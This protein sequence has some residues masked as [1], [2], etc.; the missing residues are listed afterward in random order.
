MTIPDNLNELATRPVAGGSPAGKDSRLEADFLSLQSELDRLNS[1]SG[2]SG[3]VNWQKA[4][5]G[6]GERSR[7]VGGEKPPVH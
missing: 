1:M 5:K 3:G 4:A 2:V 7:L 6:Q